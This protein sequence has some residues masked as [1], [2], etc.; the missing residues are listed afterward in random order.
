MAASGAD[1]A[2]VVL[3]PPT[4][5]SG[6]DFHEWMFMDRETFKSHPG[7]ESLSGVLLQQQIFDTYDVKQN[8]KALPFFDDKGGRMFA[9]HSENVREQSFVVEEYTQSILTKGLCPGV[10]GEP[11]GL[12]ADSPPYPLL[13]WG[14]RIRALY[15][16]VER[17]PDNEYVK[18]TLKNGLKNLTLLH[19]RVP[20]HA[21]EWLRDFHNGFHAGST[22]SFLQK[23]A[24]LPEVSANWRGHCE[25]QGF[26]TRGGDGTSSY[27]NLQ[28]DWLKN[29]YTG[30]FALGHNSCQSHSHVGRVDRQDSINCRL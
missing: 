30:R 23:L 17:E 18:L 8:N 10:G 21:R 1:G 6:S 5:K 12:W 11:W 9:P 19:P 2:L 4:P 7:F 26:T 3:P 20:R 27:A 22:T 28:R 15:R 14:T 25:A 16:A 29:L 24:W 13:T